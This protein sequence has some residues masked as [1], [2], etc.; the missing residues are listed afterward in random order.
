MERKEIIKEVCNKFRNEINDC[1]FCI[2]N[3]TYYI[4][5]DDL[6]E[7]ISKIEKES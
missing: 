4:N 3:G 5:Q 7:K 1:M 2:K 6:E